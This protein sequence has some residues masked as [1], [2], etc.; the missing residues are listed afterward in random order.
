MTNQHVQQAQPVRS[1]YHLICWL[2]QKTEMLCSTLSLTVFQRRIAA[3]NNSQLTHT[4][5]RLIIGIIC[6][7]HFLLVEY[8][9]FDQS[10]V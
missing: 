9:S 4:P 3:E 6:N 1:D 8:K 10:S 2:K 7:F 5:T